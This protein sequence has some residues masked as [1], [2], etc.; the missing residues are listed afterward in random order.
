[1]NPSQ[2]KK[3]REYRPT[4]AAPAM[5]RLKECRTKNVAENK[6]HAQ[7]RWCHKYIPQ[8]PTT[9]QSGSNKSIPST[10]KIW[11]VTS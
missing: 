9:S 6:R 2:R 3:S 7:N 11:C 5:L 8:K 10:Q 4:D 1:M